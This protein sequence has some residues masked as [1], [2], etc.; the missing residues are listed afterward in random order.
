MK[1]ITI[2]LAC[3]LSTMM[4]MGEE[5]LTFRSLPLDGDLKTAVKEVKKWGFIGMKIKNVAAM[6]GKLDGEEVILTLIAT[7]ET[8]T[9]FSATVLYEG[10]KQWDVLMTKYQLINANMTAQYGEPTELI[11]EWE[12]P[13][14][15]TNNPMQAF[16]EDKA[17]YGAV[18]DAKSGKV[19]VNILYI[20]GKMCTTVAYV[21]AQNAAL[22]QAEGGTNILIDENTDVVDTI[23]SPSL[24]QL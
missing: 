12:A 11:S 18:Y 4:M 14:S 23:N 19:A 2:I 6:M 7:P 15:L 24:Y 1:R 5:H 20:D 16:K 17:T 3:L 10:T 13:Y 9:V 22:Y 21:D 8:K